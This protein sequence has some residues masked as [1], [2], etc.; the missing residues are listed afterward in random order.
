MAT[1][2]IFIDQLDSL[3]HLFSSSEVIQN[4]IINKLE[5]IGEF[6]HMRINWRIAINFFEKLKNIQ[7]LF[8]KFEFTTKLYLIVMT[9]LNDENSNVP[10]KSSAMKILPYLLK[11][12]KKIEK[13]YILKFLDK[14]IIENKNFY[15]RR[16]YFPFF[17]EAIKI[18]SINT[19]LNYRIIDNILNFFND[20]RLMQSKL[21]TTLKSF[22]PLILSES[23]TKFIINNKLDNLK[24]FRN[25]DYELSK[26]RYMSFLFIRILNHLNNGM[27]SLSRILIIQNI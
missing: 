1:F 22:Y 20:N 15:K 26:V 13:E 27:K 4:F 11:Y 9:F 12:G 23:R 7:V 10:V 14:E 24:K 18:F 16:L 19:L 6:I 3:V 25:F 5:R 2:P 21:V 8:D 17:E